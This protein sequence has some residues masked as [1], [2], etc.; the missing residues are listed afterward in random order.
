M[1]KKL[2]ARMIATGVALAALAGVATPTIAWRNPTYTLLARQMNVREAF[3]GFAIAQG[4]SVVMSEGVAG[5]F[6]GDFRNVPSQQFL[7]QVCTMHNL[8]WYYD[9]AAIY[10]YA[11][12]EI[13][14]TLTDLAYMKV[15]DVLKLLRELG[16]E[17]SRF[18]IKTASDGEIILVSGPP[19]YVELILQTIARADRLKQM[20]TFREIET[21]IFPLKHTW[22]D[23][24]SF[25]ISGP[26]STLQITGVAQLLQDIMSSGGYSGT[27]ARDYDTNRVETADSK[28]QDNMGSGFTP[29]IRA[30]NRM[31]AVVVRDSVTRMPM[32]ERLIAELDKPQKLI[33]IAVTTVE[34][35]KDDSLDWQMSLA[36]E[37]SHK[38][39]EA[40]SAGGNVNGLMVPQSIYGRGLAGALTYV[41]KDTRISA[42]LS[43]LREKGKLRHISRTS[44]LTLNNLAA[45][46]TDT[47]SYHARCIGKEVATIEE[48]S[49]GTRLGIKP[50]LVPSAATNVQALVWLTM[51]LQ[52][53]G[54]E[55]ISVDAM[56]MTR[57]S[58]LNTQ[59]AVREG[60]AIMLAG[61]Y[62]DVKEDAGWGIPWLR[63]LPLVGWIFGGE[64]VRNE[65]IQRL[66]L[67][68]PYVIEIDGLELPRLQTRR[69]RD[70]TF[71]ETLDADA[72]ID[73]RVRKERDLR[74]QERDNIRD[75][76][77]NDRLEKREGE[78]EFRKEQRDAVRKKEMEKWREDL[79]R[80]R[81]EW[82]QGGGSPKEK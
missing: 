57:T 39:I 77:L 70:I 53:G 25:K 40:M 46:M 49:A 37:G 14:T 72:A 54:F 79:E 7:E 41:G 11:A 82:K 36:V 8:T 3:D 1:V 38:E 71:E 34:M 19:R 66:F 27:H 13:M 24:V 52:D 45:E 26:E 15:D 17:D 64:S 16:V 60:D 28:L 62:R 51:E 29:M 50:R 69:L 6:S 68:T 20:R 5:S 10:V 2:I 58:T 80:R 67:L 35:T 23:H 12:G 63:D 47:Q 43:A 4:L 30:E 48:V 59:A 42:S 33:E 55:A 44:L 61:Y 22:A 65:T 81:K 9:G 56:P 74:R 32:Y 76:D 21:R 31:N 18:P 78:M 75:E 73:L